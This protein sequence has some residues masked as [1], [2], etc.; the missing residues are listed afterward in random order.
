MKTSLT[1]L[2]W[3]S[4]KGRPTAGARATSSELEQMRARWER[5]RD[6]LSEFIRSSRMYL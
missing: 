6:E 2:P 3:Q 5:C 4:D 1:R